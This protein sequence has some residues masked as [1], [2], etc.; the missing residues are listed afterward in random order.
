MQTFYPGWLYIRFFTSAV[1]F[2]SLSLVK[3]PHQWWIFGIAVAA[4]SALSLVESSHTITISDS[5]DLTYSNWGKKQV[6]NLS[7]LT[8][9]NYRLSFGV[10]S[11]PYW[12]FHLYDASGGFVNFPASIWIHRRRLRERLKEAVITNGVTVNARTSKKLKLATK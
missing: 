10:G 1:F 7:Q 12:V 5:E 3:D 6:V 2:G 9:C 11:Y 8:N 4:A